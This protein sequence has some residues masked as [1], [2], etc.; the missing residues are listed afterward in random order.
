MN[1]WK[2]KDIVDNEGNEED[3]EQK[4]NDGD[5]SIHKS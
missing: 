5:K 2:K 4:E 3:G 1:D